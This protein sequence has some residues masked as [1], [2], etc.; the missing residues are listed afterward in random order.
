MFIAMYESSLTTAMRMTM[1]M[2]MM[3]PSMAMMSLL[4]PP[5]LALALM[6]TKCQCG[7]LNAKLPNKLT[8]VKPSS[9]CTGP[10]KDTF[11]MNTYDG[12]ELK[13][14]FSSVHC[15][16]KSLSESGNENPFRRDSN[17]LEAPLPC[18]RLF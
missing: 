2:T 9:S 1:A 16:W 12:S 6:K 3:R 7:K 18:T 5:L 4:R 17:Q 14:A 13:V 8:Q 10:N 15:K 11:S